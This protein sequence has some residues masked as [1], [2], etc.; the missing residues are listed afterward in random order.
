MCIYLDLFIILSNWFSCI[1]ALKIRYEWGQLQKLKNR[2]SSDQTH[3]LEFWPLGPFV[4]KIMKVKMY[5][6]LHL[7]DDTSFTSLPTILMLE[8]KEIGAQKNLPWDLYLPHEE[9]PGISLLAPVVS[10][11]GLVCQV[12]YLW[13][14]EFYKFLSKVKHVYNRI[15]ESY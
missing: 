2:E 14:S 7:S 6:K 9:S 13:E 11:Q 4:T 8:I 1:S 15:K 12:R 3:N 5:H 10:Y